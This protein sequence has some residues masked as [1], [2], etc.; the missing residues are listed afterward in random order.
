MICDLALHR[1]AQAW[2]DTLNQDSTTSTQNPRV[3]FTKTDVSDWSQ[4]EKA[5]DTYDKEFG[6]VPYVLC[7]GAGIYEPVC[8]QFV[9]LHISRLLQI[10]FLHGPEY[11]CC[12][13]D[14]VRVSVVF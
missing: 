6:G 12:V 1:E 3:V 11:F 8:L 2:L 9:T 10:T 13:A 5:F 4:L 7:P 14:D